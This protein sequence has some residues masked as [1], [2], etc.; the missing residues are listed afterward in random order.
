MRKLAAAEVL[1]FAAA[2]AATHGSL[3]DEPVNLAT[4]N[5]YGGYSTLS[6]SYNFGWYSGG[7]LN[8]GIPPSYLG[9]YDGYISANN[10]KA[11]NCAKAYATWG[12]GANQGAKPGFKMYI[13]A[14]HGWHDQS[15]GQYYETQPQDGNAPTPN[16]IEIGG[17]TYT[18]MTMIFTPG[19]NNGDLGYMVR[20]I[21]HEWAH[22]WGA[23]DLNDHSWND[24]YEA[25]D[26]AMA[27]FQNDKGAKCGGM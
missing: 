4:V 16:S 9:Y 25:G 14:N 2:L 21:A 20:A 17:V 8:V 5:V 15:T 10:Y 13:I 1:V 22:Q 19:A 12:P 6:A 23:L 11:L 18:D 24:A 26:Q 27:N 7:F 3:A